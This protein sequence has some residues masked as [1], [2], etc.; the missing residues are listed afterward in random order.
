PGGE[1]PRRRGVS[2]QPSGVSRRRPARALGHVAPAEEGLGRPA[3]TAP[4]LADRPIPHLLPSPPATPAGLSFR[5]LQEQGRGQADADDG[6][7]T[8][9]GVCPRPTRRGG[10]GGRLRRSQGLATVVAARV[11]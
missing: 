1:A 3:S 4:M 6:A 7:T 8:I 2:E 10:A 5:A 9:P 11:G